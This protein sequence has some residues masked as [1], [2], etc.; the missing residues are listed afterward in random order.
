MTGGR[1][2]DSLIGAE[3]NDVLKGGGGRDELFGGE[4][5]DILKGGGG[6]DTLT[7]DEGDD[8][9]DGGNG[10]DLLTGGDGGDVFV[11][12]RGHDTVTDF[13]QGDDQIDVSRYADDFGHVL[14]AASQDGSD[15]V[16]E[17]GPHSMR[18]EDFSVGQLDSDDFIF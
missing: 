12:S 14:A 8:E 1:G 4:G 13:E 3:G 16:L 11:F 5:N 10:N 15:T 2:N 18:I 9:L 17:F 7:G 6:R